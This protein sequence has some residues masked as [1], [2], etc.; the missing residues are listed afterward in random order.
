[1]P[2]YRLLINDFL[3]PTLVL[4]GIVAYLLLI[5]F[6]LPILAI[7][8]AILITLLGS[9]SLFKDTFSSLLKRQFALDYIAILAIIVA[10]VTG[11]YLVAA[12]IALMISTGN[13]LEAY[14]VNQAK[15]SLTSLADRIPD[16]VLLW[17]DNAVGEKVNIKEVNKGQ[18][19]YIRKGEVIPLDG[20]LYSEQA[21]ID[22]SSLTGEPYP[23]EKTQGDLLRSGTVNT[24]EPFVLT[25]TT[26]EKKLYLP[27][28]CHDGAGRARRKSSSNSPCRSV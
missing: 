15:K 12:I 2:N 20:Q 14:G 27:Q 17:T 26:E 9:Y 11:E 4:L 25:V 5:L 28:N 13:T 7:L 1:M 18:S 24:G 6:H 23:V 22:E 10:L 3:V 21:L 8:V 19:V 16:A